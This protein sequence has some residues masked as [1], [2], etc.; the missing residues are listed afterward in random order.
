M[1]IKDL[2]DIVQE[3]NPD[4]T[5]EDALAYLEERNSS[6]MAVKENKSPFL[7]ALKTN[8]DGEGV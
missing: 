3:R 8:P 2:A 1:G 4:M 6:S 5:R 7:N